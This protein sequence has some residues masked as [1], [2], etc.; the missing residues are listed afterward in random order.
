M[1]RAGLADTL[2]RLGKADLAIEQLNKLTDAAQQERQWLI[3]FARAYR[4][5]GDLAKAED[6]ANKAVKAKED[7]KELEAA[8]YTELSHVLLT[9][10]DLNGADIA[11]RK[12]TELNSKS[13]NA[14]EVMG[15]IYL[16]RG[17]ADHAIEA[18]KHA[19]DINPYYTPAYM[20]I[21]DAYQTSENK[22]PQAVNNYKRMP[23]NSTR[24]S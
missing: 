12:A 9:K 20:L 5:K 4:V 23:S 1:Q 18:A 6:Y 10:G 2:L 3:L 8:A 24:P 16:K 21:G 22:L 11:V 15:R 19:T 7:T 13:F 17:D 14:Y